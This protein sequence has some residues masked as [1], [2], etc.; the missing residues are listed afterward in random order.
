MDKS[1]DFSSTLT[2]GDAL[3]GGGWGDKTRGA[4]DLIVELNGRADVRRQTN[5]PT[6]LVPGVQTTFK[7][8]GSGTT[9]NIVVSEDTTA[10]ETKLNSM[11]DAYNQFI[12]V[13]NYLTG[14]KVEDDE[15][16]GSLGAEKGL[17]LIHI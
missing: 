11:V 3:T 12:T 17:S 8:V 16:A 14:D 9:I 4:Q 2:G 1:F 5:S 7:R 13:S 10:L 6:D 15:I